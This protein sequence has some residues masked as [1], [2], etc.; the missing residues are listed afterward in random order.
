MSIKSVTPIRVVLFFK[1]P[2][3]LYKFSIGILPSSNANSLL[4][5]ES[6]AECVSCTFEKSLS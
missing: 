4:P 2:F 3:L 1:K 6:I 5:F